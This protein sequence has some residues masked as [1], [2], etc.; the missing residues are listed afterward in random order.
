METHSKELKEAELAVKKIQEEEEKLKEKEEHSLF[1]M[2]S[3][4]QYKAA[5]SIKDMSQRKEQVRICLP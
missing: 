1:K 4:K 2:D 3:A 5:L